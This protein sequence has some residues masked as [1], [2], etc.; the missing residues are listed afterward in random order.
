VVHSPAIK[1]RLN[2]MGIQPVTGT[3][4]AFSR[5]I[6]DEVAKWTGV[7]KASGAEED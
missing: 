7:I 3:P 1:E 5:L 2:S 6:K 4:E